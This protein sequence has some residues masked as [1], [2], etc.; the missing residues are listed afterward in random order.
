[1]HRLGVALLSVITL[2][3]VLPSV[4]AGASTVNGSV[5][6][7]PFPELL[8][9]EFIDEKFSG[10][11]STAVFTREAAPLIGEPGPNAG[12]TTV[13]DLDTGQQRVVEPDRGA[14]GQTTIQLDL[15]GSHVL[16]EASWEEITA[17]DADDGAVD[18]FLID[19]TTDEIIAITADAAGE[20]IAAVGMDR[21]GDTVLFRSGIDPVELHVWDSGTVTD[22]PVNGTID[23]AS[24]LQLS[25]DGAKVL[26]STKEGDELTWHVQD[27][28]TGDEVTT[29][30]PAV[31]S[32]SMSEDGGVVAGVDVQWFAAT[33]SS[34]A[35]LTHVW[36]TSSGE[37][38]RFV[39]GSANTVVQLNAD[40]STLIASNASTLPAFTAGSLWQLDTVTG[41]TEGILW[42]QRPVRGLSAVSADGDRLVYRAS[43]T[44]VG[45]LPVTPAYI[46]S[47]GAEEPDRFFEIDLTGQSRP[48][49][50]YSGSLDDQLH[51]LYLAWFDRRADPSGLSHWRRVRANGAGLF[52]VSAQFFPSGEFGDT[53]GD[54]EDEAFVELVYANVLDRSPDAGGRAFWLD[55]LAGGRERSEVIVLFSE[56]PEFVERTETLPP[57]NAIAAA[58]R[59]LYAGY[60]GRDAD[61]VGLEFWTEQA[62]QGMSLEA[63]STIFLASEEFSD[64]YETSPLLEGLVNDADVLA[65]IGYGNTLGTVD[66]EAVLALSDAF[67]D[68]TI[69]LGD[70][71]VSVTSNP[72]FV[73]LTSTTPLGG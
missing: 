38:D 57:E 45:Q 27:L 58:V 35:W 42:T 12:L 40:G 62:E 69:S 67:Q 13:L 46:E 66:E 28:D 34:R 30:A 43:P 16:M 29:A 23:V 3:A 21:D 8:S 52:D 4:T 53:Y 9:G 65:V 17:G 1:M 20:N 7:L 18:V 47:R 70:V 2:T 68:G 26:Y 64:I 50:G 63:I 60:F 19:L 31:F 54:V 48:V 15:D 22:L 39:A 33:S 49:P 5:D 14:T 10:D 73:I 11:L 59:R 72:E 25:G 61:T 51:R 36:R 24:P 32:A 71:M 6:E 37:V 55:Q 41:L 56:S 44:A